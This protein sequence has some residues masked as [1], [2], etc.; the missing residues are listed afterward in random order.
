[1]TALLQTYFSFA[2]SKSISLIDMLDE[3]PF[4]PDLQNRV[5]VSMKRGRRTK[6]L[7]DSLGFTSAI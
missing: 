4:P 6:N 7:P 5:L 2:G 1:M 3:A